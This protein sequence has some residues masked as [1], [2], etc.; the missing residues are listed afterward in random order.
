MRQVK[1]W[2][3]YKLPQYTYV[4]HIKSSYCWINAH[5]AKPPSVWGHSFKNNYFLVIFGPQPHVYSATCA[6][7]DELSFREVYTSKQVINTV[8]DECL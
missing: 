6:Y 3:R 7:S 5:M 1:T 4:N 2:Q 8:C